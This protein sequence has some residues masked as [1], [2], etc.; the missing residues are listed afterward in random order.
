MYPGGYEK[1]RGM[2]RGKGEALKINP[3]AEIG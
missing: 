2:S 1:R 3:I